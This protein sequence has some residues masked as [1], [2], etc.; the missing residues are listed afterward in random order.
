MTNV[1]LENGLNSLHNTIHR[2]R[3]RLYLITSAYTIESLYNNHITCL[4]TCLHH[5]QVISAV[6]EGYHC[7]LDCIIFYLIDKYLSL[8]LE[9]RYFRDYQGLIKSL[10]NWIDPV[11]GSICPVT[12]C[13]F[14]LWLYSCPLAKTRDTSAKLANFSLVVAPLVCARKER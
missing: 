5:G 9:Y 12:V 7:L 11:V 14:P 2:N 6:L 8:L 4:E 10:W 1:V 13:I 3:L